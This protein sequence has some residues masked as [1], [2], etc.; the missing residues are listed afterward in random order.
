MAQRLVTPLEIERREY[1]KF[2]ALWKRIAEIA[3]SLNIEP[4]KKRTVARQRH[5]AN[6]SVEDIEAHYR[7]AYLYGFLDH[8]LNHFKTRVLQE[9]EGALLVTYLLLSNVKGGR[10]SPGIHNSNGWL[11]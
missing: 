10:A 4:A 8:T 1:A 11:C 9:L 7:V 6:P 3:G 5:R 2:H